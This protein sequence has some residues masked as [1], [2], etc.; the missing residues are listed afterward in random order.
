MRVFPVCMWRV[1]QIVVASVLER[2]PWLLHTFWPL[3]Y[4]HHVWG[5][6]IRI[7]IKGSAD[8]CNACMWYIPCLRIGLVDDSKR[9]CTYIEPKFVM[10]CQ[11][12]P[13]CI[14][15]IQPTSANLSEVKRKL[16]RIRPY[17]CL[18]VKN[19]QISTQKFFGVSQTRVEYPTTSRM[20]SQT[21][22]LHML[23]QSSY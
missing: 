20:I 18:V 22:C 19:P 3:H 12:L 13:C 5:C 9:Q 10:I 8:V 1:P 21:R 14:M 6:S 17:W 15:E 23:T 16:V 7:G 2:W 11:V 4:M